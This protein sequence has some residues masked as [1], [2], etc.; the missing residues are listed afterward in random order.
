MLDRTLRQL[1]GKVRSREYVVTVHA[2]E[3][4]DDDGLSILDVESGILTGEIVER[5]R[6]RETGESKYVVRGQTLTGETIGV[7]TKLSPAG[8]LVIITTYRD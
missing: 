1:R 8:H 5:Q 2:D 3:E 7:V 6:D 4:M